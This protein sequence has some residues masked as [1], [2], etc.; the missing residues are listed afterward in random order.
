MLYV[1]LIAL[2]AQGLV[3]SLSPWL[4]AKLIDGALSFPSTTVMSEAEAERK[5][6]ELAR[7]TCVS[8]FRA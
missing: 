5:T 8:W 3:V 7:R 6:L 4:S 1:A 2:S